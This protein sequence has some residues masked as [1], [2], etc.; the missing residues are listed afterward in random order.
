[1]TKKK[2]LIT[3][4]RG[5]DG[6]YLARFLLEQGYEV[7]GGDRRNSE[8]INWRLVELDVHNKI[9]FCYFDLCE[10]TNIMSVIEK[11]KPDEIYNLG[12]QSIV[13]SSFDQPLVTANTDA[14]GVLRILES[15]K[16]CS[17]K[18]K[19]YQASTSEMFGKVRESP[20]NE[21]TPFYPRSPYGVSKLFAHNATI[22]YRESYGLFCCSGI[23]FNHESPLRGVEFVTRKITSQVAKIKF[24][25]VEK[26]TLGNLDAKRDWGFA[27]DYVEIMWKMLQQKEPD[28]YVIATGETNS[29][30]KFVEKSFE[31][32][33][34]DIEWE[35]TGV[36][37]KGVDKKSGKILVEV[38][39]DFYRPAEVDQL[40]GDS[41]KAK[42]YLGW[43]PKVE[44]NQLVKIMVEADMQRLEKDILP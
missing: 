40:L 14:L 13:T 10:L 9:K 18:T 25:I 27:K 30:R 28:D 7:Y 17:P 36:S 31:I 29:V 2:A 3:G 37:E 43:K 22:N 5:Q 8:Q 35:G 4:I 34:I 26:M 19:L 16:R 24:G 20:Q 15:I 41:S 42:N 32:V 23:L 39:P 38:S 12:A 6:A 1:M 44:F 21:R 11:L 33:N